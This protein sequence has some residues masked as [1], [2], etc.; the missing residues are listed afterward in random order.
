[1][2]VARQFIA[3]YPCENGNR[4][5]GY[6]MIGSDRCA[7]IWTIN[8]SGSGSDRALRDGFSIGRVPGNKLPGYDHRVP[9]GQITPTHTSITVPP[10]VGVRLRSTHTA[11]EPRHGRTSSSI[12]LNFRCR[13]RFVRFI[14]TSWAWR[15][16]APAQNRRGV[17]C[18]SNV[19]LGAPSFSPSH[20]RR[21]AT[22]R[23]FAFAQR[24][25]SK[26]LE[27]TISLFSQSNRRPKMSPAF[28]FSATNLR[29]SQKFTD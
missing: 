23:C 19:I 20:S 18:R 12:S 27:I 2:I 7:T 10:P 14:I 25:E 16:H 9:T 28:S 22:D 21:V 17:I 1:M 8:K 11:A 5:V 29:S 4:P 24:H 3:W 15:A 26:H 13:Q 6:G